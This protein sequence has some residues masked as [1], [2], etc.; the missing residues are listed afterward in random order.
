MKLSEWKQENLHQLRFTGRKFSRIRENDV[1]LG[2]QTG[3]PRALECLQSLTGGTAV[4]MMQK[5]LHEFII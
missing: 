4:Q 3:C 2:S 5:C 1:K